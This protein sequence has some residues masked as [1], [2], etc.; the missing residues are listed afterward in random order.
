MGDNGNDIS[1][2]PGMPGEKT[3]VYSKTQKAAFC[4]FE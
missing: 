3:R 1:M 2:W 4:V